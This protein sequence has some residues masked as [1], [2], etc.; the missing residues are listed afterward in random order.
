MAGKRDI[1]D[2]D[3]DKYTMAA[4][5]NEEL[6]NSKNAGAIDISS[7]YFNVAG[8]NLL[9]ESLWDFTKRQ[10]FKLR[11]LF[12]KE[13]I[14]EENDAKSFE[15]QIETVE[16]TTD[17]E[18][19]VAKELSG[20]TLEWESAKTVDDLVAFLKQNKVEVKTNKN[21]FN[22]SKCYILDDSAVVGSSNL[23][24][25]GLRHNVELNAVLYQA[26]AIKEV[27]EWFEKRWLDAE[28]AKAELIKTLEESKFGHPLEPFLMYMKLLYEY[29]RPRLEELEKSKA[30]RVELTEFQRDAVISAL[31][32]L[33]KYGGVVIA[34]ST[35]LGKTHI[36]LSL[37]R[38]LASVRRK[39]V[40][41]VAPRQVLDSVWEPRLLDESIKTKNRSLEVT[42]TDSFDPTDYLD[43]DVVIVDESHNYRSASTKRHNNIMKVLAGGKRKQVI[44]MTATPVN[45]SLMDLYNQLSLIT[46]G[47]DTHFA[48]LGIGDLKAYFVSADRKQLASG[49]EDIVRLLDEIMIRRTRAFIKENY[50]EATLND[51]RI[52]FPQRRLSKVQYSLTELFGPKIYNQVIETIDNLNLVPYR[53]D[54]YRI[55]IEEEE[56]KEVEQ[57]ASLQKYG[58]LK[59]FE[60]SVEAIRKSIDRLLKFYTTFA[61]ALD[62]GKILNNKQFHEL[63][64]EFQDEEEFD[65]DR[66]LEELAKIALEPA[67]SL[68]VKRMKKELQEDIERLEPLK[69]NLHS[70]PPWGDSKLN[71]LKNLFIR[72]KI[73]ETG[74]KKAVIFTQFV[75]T[76]NY[77]YEDLKKNMP[78]KKILILTGRTNQE[79]RKKLLLEF[80]PRSNNP[81][82]KI[83]EREGDILVSSEV[84]S[85]GQNLQDA[86]YAINYDLPWNPMKIVQRVG[87]VDRL[88]TQFPEVT[89]AVFFP[90][91]ELEDE[92]GLL[93]K[94]TKKI[95]KAAG[96]VGVESSILGERASPK[97]FN[98]FEKIKTEDA[99][100]LD[101]MERSAELLPLMTPYQTVLSYLKKVGEK[102]LK[103]IPYGKRSG[104]Q[105]QE[106]GIV[107]VYREK[108]SKDSIHFLFFDYKNKRIDHVGDINWIFRLLKCEEEEPLT[109]PL[110]GY[111]LFRQLKIVDEKARQE[112][113]IAVNAPF[114]ARKT[115]KIK[116][117]YQHELVGI[118]FQMVSTG[119]ATKEEIIPVYSV[120]TSA[121]FAAWDND[122]KT[123]Y[124]AYQKNQD[125]HSLVTSLN[126]LFEQYKIKTRES[127]SPKEV[128]PEDLMLVGCMFLSNPSFKD[129][130]M[131]A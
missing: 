50:P 35:G 12:G 91:K 30:A 5:L 99:S 106:S 1:I 42:G 65:D 61:R 27:K 118:L 123:M 39:K 64:S 80:A 31:R 56:K 17:K 92:L 119:K 8:Y 28:D 116:P 32:I 63:L 90:E 16:K 55:D 84:L 131:L 68:D 112:I 58:L 3:K 113:L 10:E 19:S 102:E 38:E 33:D 105:S 9:R 125:I 79:T 51:R 74:G 41:L 18:Y 46:G 26:S 62:E 76:A 101:D 93:V 72:D 44:L 45:N 25:A 121:N 53:V 120:I 82:N 13:A 122:F 15:E 110:E 85:E 48:D 114:N 96:T 36:G 109:I 103:S 66:F 126:K 6:K 71:A 117:K 67:K 115:Q 70:M 24:A 127:T 124:E 52:T 11:M 29:Y 87:R 4:F 104:R 81:E 111:E 98:A 14:K 40:L 60:S 2:N 89:S 108:R 21:R 88:T 23:T 75:D 128:K 43:Y 57:R 22:H 20:M 47:D 107:L 86:N 78:E 83:V 73:F 95:Q 129:W 34:D 54:T 94:L 7:G 59:R 49:I 130:N 100:L 69:T 77:V 97:N 37:L